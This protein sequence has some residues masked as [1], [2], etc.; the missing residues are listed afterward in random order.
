MLGEKGGFLAAK[1][2]FIMIRNEEINFKSQGFHGFVEFVDFM[3]PPSPFPHTQS[4]Y[5]FPFLSKYLLIC[6]LQAQS[7]HFLCPSLF[8]PWST[9]LF[10]SREIRTWVLQSLR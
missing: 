9:S 7:Q 6:T 1:L 10:A 3:H 2:P 4:F 5:N 8:L